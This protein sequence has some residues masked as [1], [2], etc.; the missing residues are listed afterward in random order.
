MMQKLMV[1][2]RSQLQLPRKDLSLSS[3]LTPTQYREV[4]SS[5]ELITIGPREAGD[6]SGMLQQDVLPNC[7]GSL[8]WLPSENSSSKDLNALRHTSVKRIEIV[9]RC[10]QDFSEKA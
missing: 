1:G 5:Q 6:R 3:D 8:L 9:P 2:P 10:Y 4:P 7:T